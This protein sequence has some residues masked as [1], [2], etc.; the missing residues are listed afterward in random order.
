M[1]GRPGRPGRRG[2]PRQG[3]G[4]GLRHHQGPGA[5]GGRAAQHVEAD[6]GREPV[7]ARRQPA[8]VAALLALPR[9]PAQGP[10]RR[11]GH[12]GL[13]PAGGPPHRMSLRGA[14]DVRRSGRAPGGSRE[15]PGWVPG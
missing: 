11:S 10:A 15:G 2:P 6:P 4:A 13:R 3:V 5:V 14:A 8:P 1:G 7:D 9:S 12:P